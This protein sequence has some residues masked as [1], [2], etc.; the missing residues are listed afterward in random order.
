[1]YFRNLAG[2]PVER[3]ADHQEH[4]VGGEPLRF[5]TDDFG[6]APTK[7]DRLH[8]PKRDASRLHHHVALPYRVAAAI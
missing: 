4:P 3:A 5:L 1:M 8:C 2:R 7:R 6:G